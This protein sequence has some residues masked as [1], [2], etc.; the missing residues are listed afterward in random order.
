MKLGL[1]VPRYGTEVVGGTEHWLRTLCEHLVALRGWEAEVFTTCAV[2]A[3]TWADELPAG[4]SCINDVTVHRHRSLS[5]RDPAYLDLYGPIRADPE[6]VPDVMARRFVELVG[7]VC[8][9]AV[10]EAEASD[11]DLIAATPY[12]FWPVVH[13][14]PRLGR[15]VIFHGAAHDEAEL[16]LPLMRDVFHAVGGFSYNS[17]AERDLV[18]RTFGVAH[19]PSSVIGNA[20][21]EGT[22]DPEVARAALGLE[23]DEPFVLCLGRVERAKGAHLLADLWGLYRRRRPHAPRLVFVGPVHESLGSRDGVVVAGLQPEPVK[24]GA[25]VGCEFVVSPSAWESFSLVV[26]EGWLA[27][28]AALV[29]GRCEPTVEHCARSRGGLWFDQYG[30]FEV[31]VDRLTA[32]AAWRDRLAANGEEYARRLFSWPVITERYAELAARIVTSWAG[33]V[34]TLG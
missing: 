18:Q 7:P 6:A 5:G 13:G 4:D 15:R 33:H 32:D 20:V 10:D 25:L 8:P 14:V 2:S 23:A 26:V 28:K 29:N 17:F 34:G 16:H 22:G 11:C 31:A 21:V 24:W 27:G 19:L 9:D 3:A 1:V 12:L 30:D